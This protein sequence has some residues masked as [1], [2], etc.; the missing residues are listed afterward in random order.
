MPLL[1]SASMIGD[2]LVRTS[3]CQCVTASGMVSEQHRRVKS[4]KEVYWIGRLAEALAAI[5]LKR[6]YAKL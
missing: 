5:S 4:T 3:H 6:E 1:S 2:A